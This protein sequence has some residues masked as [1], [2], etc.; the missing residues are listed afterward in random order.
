MAIRFAALSLALPLALLIALLRAPGLSELEFYAPA[1]HFYVVSA[2]SLLAAAVCAVLVLSARSIRQTRILFLALCFFSLGMIFAV[3][4]LTTP[5]HLYN[6]FTAALERSPW[7]STLAG[8]FFAALSVV[9]IPRVMER[10]RLRVPE[11]TFAFCT[12]LIVA[13]SAI[14]LAFPDW[15]TGFP[16]TEAW[17]RHLLS[18]VTIALLSF[19]AWRYFQSYLF[20]RLPAQ[21]AV[22]V[23]LLFL[24][25]AQV[26]L[27]LGEVYYASWWTYHGLFLAAFVAVLG[28]WTWELLRAK[29]VRSIAEAIAMRDALTQL[30]RGRPYPLVTLADQIENHDLETFRHVDR[31]A[32]CAYAISREMDFGPGRLRDLVLAAQMHDIGKI[33]LP[34]YIL[35]KPG[36]L[37]DEEWEQIKLHP[38]KGCEIVERVRGLKDIA[39]VIRHHH[40]R[41]DGSGYPDAAAG[42]AIPLEARI[43]SVADTLD[44]LTSERPY[45]GAMSLAEAREEV[46]RVS[47]SQLDPVCVQALLKV[48]EAGSETS[49]AVPERLPAE[50]T[51]HL[52][53]SDG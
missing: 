33:G 40:E 5:G 19:A 1:F 46:L 23:G 36:K 43:I 39:T 22:G 30:N 27:D 52:A 34:P 18:A 35:T 41:F 2:A 50:T 16:T 11:I 28:G 7:L 42:D 31:V 12:G 37:T 4:G 26:S 6:H 8:G 29:D 10:T 51:L 24:A 21:L 38:G 53:R 48:L 25:E 17:F 32:A 20:A 15:L 14:S 44:A 9:S 3:H 13:Y 47:G 49:R 45:R